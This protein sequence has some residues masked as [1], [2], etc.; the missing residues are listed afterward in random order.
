MKSKIKFLIVYVLLLSLVLHY[1]ITVLAES[2]EIQENTYTDSTS[3]SA[4]DKQEW[5]VEKDGLKFTVAY[6]TKIQCGTPTTFEF[7]AKYA[8]DPTLRQGELR[9]RIHSL[10]VY[11]GSEDV[12]VYDVSYGSNSAYTSDATFDFTFYASGTYYIRFEALYR[13]PNSDGTYQILGCVDTGFQNQGI[14]LK[15]DDPQYP[16]VENIVTNVASECL[17]KCST[18]YEKALWLNDWIVDH[19]TYDTT[20]SYCSAEGALARGSGTCE[21]YHR[22]YVMLLNKVGIS[23]GRI[24]GNGHV[25]TAVK[26]NGE[27]YQVD[28]TWNDPGYTESNI[29]LR[30]LYFGLNDE[31]M[32]KVHS[33]HNPVQG[34]ES[35]SLEQNYFIQS[36]E[37]SKWSDPVINIVREHIDARDTN[38]S[39]EINQKSPNDS[40]YAS[41]Y[42]TILYNLVAY[43]LTNTSWSDDE[44]L[45]IDLNAAYTPKDNSSGTIT[46]TVQYTA[47]PLSFQQVNLDAD[48]VNIGAN[49][50]LSY[51]VNRNAT[52]TVQVF[53]ANDQCLQTLVSNK[54]IGTNNQVVQWNLKNN[55]GAY[56]PNGSYHFTITA[57]DASG[58]SIVEHK[59][60]NVTGNAGSGSNSDTNNG[61]SEQ[62]TPGVWLIDNIGWWFRYP[63]GSY[64]QNAWEKIDGHWYWFNNRGYMAVGWQQIGGTWYYLSSSGAMATGWQY[65]GGAWYYLMPSGAMATGWQY[66][67]GAWYYLMPSGAMATGWQYIGGAW[68]YLMSSGAMATGWQYI[69]GAWYYL[70]SSGAMAANTWVGNFYV[71]GSGVWIP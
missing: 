66:I 49:A 15:I 10:T 24:T 42:A 40:D 48:S 71:N 38:F 6:P 9:Y 67:G 18:D 46:C 39:I 1:P 8:P 26:M 31:I 59:Y 27:W 70:M 43:V 11:D 56:V 20:Y 37:I 64:P 35:T 4:A 19:C 14:V 3:T 16:S 54:A 25:W 21:A 13:K 57:K 36:K 69:G 22:A 33:D 68:Y 23:T 44:A 5:T 52:V 47:I 30:H 45:N 55:S 41:A 17:T 34:Y 51:A 7:D 53:D 2:G 61:G 12:S 50:Q 32:K 65:I 29:D 28:T 62:S 58:N 63:N 60:F